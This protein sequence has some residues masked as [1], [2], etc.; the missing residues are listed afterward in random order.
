MVC[1]SSVSLPG[2]LGFLVIQGG[3]FENANGRRAQFRLGKSSAYFGTFLS[4]ADEY[5][6]S[7][8]AMAPDRESLEADIDLAATLSQESF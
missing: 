1:P 2:S 4:A 8:V 3:D 7:H 6:P 5:P